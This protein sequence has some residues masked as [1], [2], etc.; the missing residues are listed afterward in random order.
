MR[1]QFSTFNHCPQGKVALQDML[2]TI[3]GQLQALGHEAE[4]SDGPFIGGVLGYNVVVEAF[5]DPEHVEMIRAACADG[6]R[7]LYLATEQPTDL[8]FNYGTDPG[9]IRRQQV[10]PAAATYASGI[11][12]LVPGIDVRNWYSRFAPAAYLE[13]G[14]SEQRLYVGPE[15]VEPQFD[16]GFY[17]QITPRRRAILDR[18][19]EHGSVLEIPGLVMQQ[20]ERDAEMRR[21]RVIVQIRA[22][23]DVGYV[24]SS[25]CASALHL[26]RP[27]VAEPHPARGLWGS[28]IHFSESLE[29]F[30]AD[31]AAM[32]RNS[33]PVY[34]EQ[35][36]RFAETFPP[37]LCV[38]RP[39]RQLGIIK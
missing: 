9:M 11:L 31:A 10:F 18:L 35:I 30:Y 16:F 21:C 22:T 7:F 25:R 27:V 33:V 8:G 32:A 29:A 17:G 37:D 23:D 2:G 36:T 34:N 28:V 14:F 6:C 13:L 38:G 19:A 1:F 26:R 12:H 4:T 3:A 15:A 24:S 20:P 5:E 39:L